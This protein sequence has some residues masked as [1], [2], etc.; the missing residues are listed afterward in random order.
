MVLWINGEWRQ[1]FSD[2]SECLELLEAFNVRYR[3]EQ[4]KF[5]N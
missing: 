3:F 1:R 2:E 5:Q 4:R